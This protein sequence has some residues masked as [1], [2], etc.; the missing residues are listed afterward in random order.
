[1]VEVEVFLFDYMIGWPYGDSLGMI[2][3][4]HK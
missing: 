1:M 3:I 4:I 2:C